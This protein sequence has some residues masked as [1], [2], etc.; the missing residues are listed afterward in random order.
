M[1][2]SI[3]SLEQI[4]IMLD[5]NIPKKKEIIPLTKNMFYHPSMKSESEFRELSEYPYITPDVDYKINVYPYL[6][7][8]EYDVK[9]KFFF[10]S[11]SQL[12][13]LSTVGEYDP[14]S[15]STKN[16]AS[17][18]SNES[19]SALTQDKNTQIEQAQTKKNE[20]K[21]EKQK[22]LRN[23]KNLFEKEQKKISTD[24]VFDNSQ[25]GHELTKTYSN[26]NN[27][28][29][30][31]EEIIKQI[32]TDSYTPRLGQLNEHENEILTDFKELVKIIKKNENEQ[33]ITTI[34]KENVKEV[35]ETKAYLP[36][37]DELLD[38]FS[39]I[40]NGV[41]RFAPIEE[42]ITD[43]LNKIKKNESISISLVEQ[44]DKLKGII[45]NDNIKKVF[46]PI[47]IEILTKFANNKSSYLPYY[48]IEI[49]N[50]LSIYEQKEKLKE[51]VRNIDKRYEEQLKTILDNNSKN[52]NNS[53]NQETEENVDTTKILRHNIKI[54][55]LLF[56][57][58]TFP[59]INNIH[60][61]F[62]QKIK[63]DF[64]NFSF[65]NLWRKNG[66]YEDQN[67]SYI[68]MNEKIYTVI[69]VIWLND[70]YNHPIYKK[71]VNEY[72]LFNLWKQKKKKN[73]S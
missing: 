22:Q 52:S 1:A 73:I 50:L 53:P 45:S 39:H 60:A 69:R 5:T 32:E 63:K 67:Y 71:I 72:R 38:V 17:Q 3:I 54:M 49:P 4:K 44:S 9:L 16:S 19:S 12:K 33:K 7:T 35:Q 30:Q 15:V 64:T 8:K 42:S 21:K 43:L 59:L 34:K 23:I 62:K 28:I 14:T 20:E 37:F 65:E 13:I 26:I 61:S 70:I 24:I 25:R 27:I 41:Y 47:E 31:I 2:K 10:N 6:S 18:E 56:F 58:T 36:A 51:D 29:D 11:E 55:F 40:D 46:S 57:P 66:S 68:K 48:V